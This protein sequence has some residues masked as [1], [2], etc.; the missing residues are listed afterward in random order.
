MVRLTL[1]VIQ[2]HFNYNIIIFFIDF[3]VEVLD[4]EFG[5]EC[6]TVECVEETNDAKGE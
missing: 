2:M 4:E 6:C 3:A 5:D 1:I